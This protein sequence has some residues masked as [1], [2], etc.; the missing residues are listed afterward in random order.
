MRMWLSDELRKIEEHLVSFLNVIAARAEQE[1]AYVMP[2]YTHIQRVQSIRWSHWML[3]YGFDFTGDL[4]KLKGV[5]K[6]VNGNPLSC[7][8]LACNP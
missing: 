8:A 1:I 6:C 5:I 3:P 7:G 4:E 2:G